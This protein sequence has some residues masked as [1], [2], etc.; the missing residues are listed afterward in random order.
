MVNG[1]GTPKRSY[2]YAADL[3]I[4]LW[5]ILFRAPSLDA[6]NV[7]SDQSISIL[8]LAQKVVSSLRST[9]TVKVG[10][11]PIAGEPMK[12]YVPSIEKAQQQ[13]GLKLRVSLEEAIRRTAAWHGYATPTQQA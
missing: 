12:Q 7:G 4:W 10:Q 1:D 9:A 11:M 6:F 2:M 5:S 3:A 8:E 13:L